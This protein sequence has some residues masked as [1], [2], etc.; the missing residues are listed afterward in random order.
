[1]SQTEGARKRLGERDLFP[2]I[3]VLTLNM[4]RCEMGRASA[5]EKAIERRRGAC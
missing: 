2:T 4:L 1:M 3:P 5:I